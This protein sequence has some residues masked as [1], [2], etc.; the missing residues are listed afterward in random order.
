MEI[1]KADN[2]GIRFVLYHEKRNTLRGTISRVLLKKK[3]SKEEF[4]A[5]RNVSFSVKKGDILGVIGSNGSGKSTLLRLIGH[6]FTPNEGALTVNGTVSTLL[7][8]TAGFQQELTGLD[9]IYL[10][11]LLMGFKLSDIDMVVDDIINFSELEKFIE[12]PV[13]TYSAGMY[14]RLGFSIAINLKRDIMLIDEI[15]GVGDNMFRKKCEKK[16]EELLRENRTIILVS[17]SMDSIKKF[18]NKAILLDKGRIM[19]AGSPQ[20]VTNVYL[21]PGLDRTTILS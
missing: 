8:V 11:G 15:L 19:A 1:I 18:A 2:L 16:F 10:S 20:E 13:K 4:W 5:L 17:H 6:I 14:A 12:M 9:N 21:G 3:R 7:S